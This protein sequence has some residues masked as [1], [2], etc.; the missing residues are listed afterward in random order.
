[1]VILDQSK[2]EENDLEKVTSHNQDKQDEI[3]KH[4][5]ILKLESDSLQEKLIREGNSITLEE[6]KDLKKA[7]E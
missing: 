7:I 3:V 2:P 4:L 5:V 6:L 1:M